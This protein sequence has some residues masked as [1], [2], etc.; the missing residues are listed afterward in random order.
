MT[1]DGVVYEDSAFYG[2]VQFHPHQLSTIPSN[3][4]SDYLFFY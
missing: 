3:V 2:M 4:E 1:A